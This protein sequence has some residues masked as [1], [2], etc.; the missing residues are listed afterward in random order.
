MADECDTKVELRK[1]TFTSLLLAFPQ[2]AIVCAVLVL[3]VR[4]IPNPS[5]WLVVPVLVIPVLSML[6][7]TA[8]TQRWVYSFC[9]RT[10]EMT[11]AKQWY[12]GQSHRI[13]VVPFAEITDIFVRK[14]NVHDGPVWQ[15]LVLYGGTTEV[16]LAARSSESIALSGRDELRNM[17]GL[18]TSTANNN[19]HRN[20]GSVRNLKS[21]S[22]PASGDV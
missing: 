16:E 22:L 8:Y 17:V 2:A 19:M 12:C 20:A 1:Y 15:V 6:P 14:V 21:T 11:I 18:R 10:T 3:L 7:F 9:P 4:A 5:V 13:Q